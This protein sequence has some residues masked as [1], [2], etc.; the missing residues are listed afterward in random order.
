LYRL[1]SP[2]QSTGQLPVRDSLEQAEC[3]P[4]ANPLQIAHASPAPVTATPENSR[5]L[6]RNIMTQHILAALTVAEELSPVNLREICGFL[7]TPEHAW[8]PPVMAQCLLQ[9]EDHRRC[10]QKRPELRLL[11]IDSVAPKR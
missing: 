4:D 8:M 2:D 11:W 1:I 9:T 3:Q 5:H 7:G 6:L 10:A